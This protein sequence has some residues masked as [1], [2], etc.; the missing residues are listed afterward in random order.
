MESQQYHGS[1]TSLHHIDLRTLIVHFA[2]IA[3]LRCAGSIYN[4]IASYRIAHRAYAVAHTPRR[5]VPQRSD[6]ASYLIVPRARH[7][8][9]L[10]TSLRLII[11]LLYYYQEKNSE[12]LF[13]SFWKLWAFC[14]IH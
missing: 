14:I 9:E 4:N 8:T 3:A 1:R 12:K 2:H 5:A 10:E 13:R 11:H 6:K 7:C